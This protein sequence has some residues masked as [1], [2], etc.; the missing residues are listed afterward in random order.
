M[1]TCND[2]CTETSHLRRSKYVLQTD[3]PGKG[4]EVQ[5]PILESQSKSVRDR[6]E[7]GVTTAPSSAIK[8]LY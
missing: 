3:T 6:N 1:C 5:M 4:S 8:P 7:T 2:R